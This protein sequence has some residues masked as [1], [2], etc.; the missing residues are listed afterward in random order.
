M[1]WELSRFRT[2]DLVEV[3]SKNEI[4]ATLDENGCLDGMPFMPEMV[5]YCGRQ[6]EV[7]QHRDDVLEALFAVARLVDDFLAIGLVEFSLLELH[8]VGARR[9][10]CVH[11]LL[12]DREV[13]VVVET[14]FG[15]HIA[16]FSR[17]DP[18]RADVESPLSCRHVM[19]RGPETNPQCASTPLRGPPSW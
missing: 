5:P 3:R 6:F 13:A 8:R 15:D 11:E 9:G 10:R 18:S 17:T 7:D 1:S 14:D 16:R 4:L 19:K 2:G 12:R